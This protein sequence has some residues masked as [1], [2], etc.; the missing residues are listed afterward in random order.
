MER[1]RA[2]TSVAR[3]VG[4]GSG[5]NEVRRGL[6]AAELT[7]ARDCHCVYGT[8]D[9]SLRKRSLWPRSQ[10]VPTGLKDSTPGQG[11]T[12]PE[13]SWPAHRTIPQTPP[14]RNGHIDQLAMPGKLHPPGPDWA[15][16]QEPRLRRRT[17]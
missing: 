8:W 13:A 14:G 10:D 15:Q 12:D 17:Q 6:G 16:C 4:E 5:G 1:A 9:W 7:H 2:E 3:A 11:R